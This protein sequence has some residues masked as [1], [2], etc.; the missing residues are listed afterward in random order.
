MVNDASWVIE[1]VS[2]NGDTSKHMV[3]KG[4]PIQMAD[5]DPY[6]WKTPI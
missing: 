6:F 2:I 3:Y 1:W 4:K 5:L